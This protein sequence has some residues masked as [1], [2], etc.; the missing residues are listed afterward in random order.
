MTEWFSKY[1]FLPS[2]ISNFEWEHPLYLYSL[3]LIPILFLL[4]DWL[5]SNSTQKLSVAFPTN[6]IKS[7]WVSF[8]RFIPGIFLMFTIALLIIAL[9]RPQR[10]VSESDQFA[11]GIDIMLAMDISKS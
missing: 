3:P 1:W 11:E 4:R 7:N 8:L 2:T 10:S 9:A 5:R 6:D